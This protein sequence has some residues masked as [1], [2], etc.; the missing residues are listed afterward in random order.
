MKDAQTD[1][2]QSH[3]STRAKTILAR[4]MVAAVPTIRELREE[5]IQF[6]ASRCPTPSYAKPPKPSPS[7][8]GAG[9][10]VDRGHVDLAAAPV[11]R[12]SLRHLGQQDCG[13]ACPPGRDFIR[14][15]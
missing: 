14:V 5:A 10:T 2:M 1:D 13:F 6:L 8:S 11:S 15:L 7:Q 9:P 12:K 3:Q 4:L